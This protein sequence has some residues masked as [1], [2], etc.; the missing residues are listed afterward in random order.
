MA[1]SEARK[2]YV[3]S[4]E[5]A[6]LQAFAPLRP[7]PAGKSIAPPEDWS[8][9]YDPPQRRAV[10]AAIREE[11]QEEEEAGGVYKN[12]KRKADGE[13]GGEAFRVA[14][15]FAVRMPSSDSDGGSVPCI[16]FTLYR[17]ARGVV[18]LFVDHLNRCGTRSGGAL[19]RMLD[20]FAAAVGARSA[21][22][23]D[24]AR[25]RPLTAP[26]TGLRLSQL[27]LLASGGRAAYYSQFG[28][29][30]E[31]EDADET[32]ARIRA[33]AA[34]LLGAP[35]D[36]AL[37]EEWDRALAAAPP[38]SAVA[39]SL[40]AARREA[41]QF[42]HQARKRANWLEETLLGAT[43]PAAVAA[44]ALFASLE[45]DLDTTSVPRVFAAL[46]AS[47]YLHETVQA[48]RELDLVIKWTQA[49]LQLFFPPFDGEPGGVIEAGP[50]YIKRYSSSREEEESI[51]SSSSGSSS[52][53]TEKSR[54]HDL[55]F[56]L[57]D[58]DDNNNSSSSSDTPPP[59][60]TPLKRRRL[61]GGAARSTT[62]RRSRGGSRRTAAGKSRRRRTTSATTLR[63][64][65]LRAA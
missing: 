56:L 59:P 24:A 20:V 39:Q 47:R 60:P 46:I 33:N 27:W 31:D 41:A 26:H 16:D 15:S 48:G 13:V 14:R 55:S 25:L 1:S 30:H 45:V 64:G 7:S 54:E 8:M 63:A 44:R 35:T 17:S 58:S 28:Y 57:D 6:A 42:D 4:I 11:K 50:G 32:A 36:A 34:L 2:R 10:E 29:D 40:L 12:K 37:G 22:L 52:V 5:A 49:A 38:F 62:S 53:E 18:H 23:L 43:A 3:E 9:M 65:R 21:R 61:S 51:I 19:L